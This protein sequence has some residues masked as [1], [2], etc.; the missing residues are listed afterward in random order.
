MDLKIPWKALSK[1]DA[2][3]PKRGAF[4]LKQIA[5]LVVVGVA[6][7]AGILLRQ[8][9][10]RLSRSLSRST[11]SP[12]H[13]WLFPRQNRPKRTIKSLPALKK[14]VSRSKHPGALAYL[15]EAAFSEAS[16][17]TV[18]RCAAVPEQHALRHK[19]ISLRHEPTPTHCDP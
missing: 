1:Q 14:P 13:R 10:R 17:A 7:V 6:L 2:S 19:Q 4:S 8:S 11:D 3:S 5:F 15:G 16:S 18:T 12:P 9:R